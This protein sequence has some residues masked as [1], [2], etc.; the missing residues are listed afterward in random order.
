MISKNCV[1]KIEYLLSSICLASINEEFAQPS[2]DTGNFGI[3]GFDPKAAHKQTINAVI[4]PIM[5]P[6]SLALS[7]SIPRVKIP[8]MG[9]PIAPWMLKA[10]AISPPI[11]FANNAKNKQI[12]PF[13]TVRALA[14]KVAF[15]S[16]KSIPNFRC[17]GLT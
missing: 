8:R 10:T 2:T 13:K 7:D 9:P 6:I 17:N 11:V 3:G 1:S 16:E 12:T 14:K 4:M 15:L 5:V